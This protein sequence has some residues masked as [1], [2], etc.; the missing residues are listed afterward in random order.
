M[1]KFY[2]SFLVFLFT[3]TAAQAIVQDDFVM[4]SLQ[5]VPIERPEMNL[6]YDYQCTEAIPI[7]LN[8]LEKVSSE[9]NLYE[10]QTLRFKVAQTIIYKGRVLAKKDEIV[11][12]RVETVIEN[13][14][15]G[16][17]AS[18]ILGNFRLAKV[19]NSKLSAYYKKSG[20]D[21][22]LLV[23]PLKWALTVLPP[24]GSLTNLIKGGHVKFKPNRPITIYYYPEWL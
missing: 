8:I 13:G 12:A 21:L 14:M 2:F 17:P 20:R 3:M 6:V 19:K 23:F 5:N 18:V 15:N 9:K 22:S 1:N 24:T 7:K 10:G 4:N 11:T 16:I